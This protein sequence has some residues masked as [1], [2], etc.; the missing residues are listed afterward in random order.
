MMEK[1][2]PDKYNTVWEPRKET[3]VRELMYNFLFWNLRSPTLE[4]IKKMYEEYESKE[5]IQDS[6]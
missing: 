6:I 2:T 1:T 4:E 3:V 5:R